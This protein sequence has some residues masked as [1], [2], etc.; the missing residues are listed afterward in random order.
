MIGQAAARDN[1]IKKQLYDV[2]PA[3][4]NTRTCRHQ[5]FGDKKT[6]LSK[7]Y[8]YFSNQI[9]KYIQSTQ[10]KTRINKQKIKPVTTHNLLVV[11]LVDR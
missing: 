5:M 8:V 9:Q 4:I 7:N 1:G 2:L 6:L 11:I 10:N 3:T